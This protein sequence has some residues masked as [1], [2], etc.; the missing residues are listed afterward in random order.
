MNKYQK[1]ALEVSGYAV[2]KSEIFEESN[3]VDVSKTKGRF[4]DIINGG[5]A[6]I[7]INQAE[8]YTIT[9]YFLRF[10]TFVH[11][12]IANGVTYEQ[13]TIANSS[14]PSVI[15]PIDF[16]HKIKEV[17]LCYD[18]ALD[19]ISVPLK[20]IEADKKAY[21]EKLNAQK[22][23]EYEKRAEIKTSSG[24]ALV[25]VYFKPCCKEYKKSVIE[26]YTA[27]GKYASR[28]GGTCVA[29]TPPLIGGEAQQ[30][31]G[32]FNV[33]EG[34]L[35]KSIPGLAYGVYGIKVIQFDKNGKKLFTSDYHF[36][37]IMS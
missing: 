29:Y 12:V 13:R 16:N 31:I 15:V 27:K 10:Q 14:Y 32:K 22:E 19:P 37:R 18:G 17:K 11:T 26:L 20:Y 30:L 24:N 28:G 8:D 25:N 6:L 3:Q 35:F 21:D 33:E 5:E 36:F 9:K 2:Y 23:E 1:V 34:M 4:A 7:V